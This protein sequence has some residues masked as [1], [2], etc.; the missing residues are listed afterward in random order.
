MTGA[1]M[2]RKHPSEGCERRS[3]P[4]LLRAQIM[5]RQEGR[6]FDCGTRMILGQS[7]T[8]ALDHG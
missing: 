2:Q 8:V 4:N 5:L 7:S 1:V 3:L 6:C